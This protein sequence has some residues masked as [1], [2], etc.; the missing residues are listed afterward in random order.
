MYNETVIN[1]QNWKLPLIILDNLKPD[2][3]T[4]Q[5]FQFGGNKCNRLWARTACL[6]A[7]CVPGDSLR[8]QNVTKL[9]HVLS[10][11]DFLLKEE[12]NYTWKLFSIWLLFTWQHGSEHV[13]FD[14]K[15]SYYFFSF[16]SLIMAA[17]RQCQ[18]QVKW[19]CVGK[20]AN[21]IHTTHLCLAMSTLY[22]KH[23]TLSMMPGLMFLRLPEN[24]LWNVKNCQMFHILT[25]WFSS[26]NEIFSFQVR[27]RQGE[28]RLL[29]VSNFSHAFFFLLKEVILDIYACLLS[30]TDTSPVE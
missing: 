22:S 10:R 11:R 5:T 25:K 29:W 7:V 13:H 8:H 4:L 3:L 26:W 28:C 9:W 30:G 6:C 15:L 24:T 14:D 12:L 23:F 21:D 20:L 1:L 18:H 19:N 17:A 27:C 16:F 2:N